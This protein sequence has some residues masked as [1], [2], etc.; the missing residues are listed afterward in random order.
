[1]CQQY[2]KRWCLEE[3]QKRRWI[4]PRSL[5]LQCWVRFVKNHS[6]AI[7]SA[8]PPLRPP[9]SESDLFAKVVNIRHLGVH[10]RSLDLP[11]MLQYL[12]T[13]QTFATLHGDTEVSA[14]V[15]YIATRLQSVHKDINKRQGQLVDDLQ[16]TIHNIRSQQAALEKTAKAEVV[17]ANQDNLEQAGL[18]VNALLDDLR[19][20]KDERRLRDD[21]PFS[22]PSDIDEILMEAASL[23]FH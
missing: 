18:Q 22:A 16:S 20:Q 11:M 5:E 12:V 6:D 13:A 14:K 1:M 9:E 3:M 4:E 8:A 10:R 23:L 17:R 15:S 7:S 2:G 19:W 21:S